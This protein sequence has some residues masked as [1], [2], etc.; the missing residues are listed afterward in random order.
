MMFGHIELRSGIRQWCQWAEDTPIEING[1]Q[2]WWEFCSNCS[3][4]F[5]TNGRDRVWV[6]YDRPEFPDLPDATRTA[7]HY[8]RCEQVPFVAGDLGWE[9][10]A[11]L[12]NHDH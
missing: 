5:R 1:L 11:E 4:A 9:E 10:A 3:K 8:A 6:R 2:T 12:L 7:S